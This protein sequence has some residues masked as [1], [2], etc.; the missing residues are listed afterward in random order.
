MDEDEPLGSSPEVISVSDEQETEEKPTVKEDPPKSK[1]LKVTIETLTLRPV[2]PVD[3]NKR[4]QTARR[5]RGFRPDA[6]KQ[7]GLVKRQHIMN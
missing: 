7:G 6:P 3:V 5:G 4:L 2:I 1:D